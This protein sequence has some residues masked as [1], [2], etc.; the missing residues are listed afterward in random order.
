M[1]DVQ[2]ENEELMVIF[3]NLIRSLLL[4]VTERKASETLQDD[5]R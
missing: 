5:R 2:R 4:H 3:T 1:E